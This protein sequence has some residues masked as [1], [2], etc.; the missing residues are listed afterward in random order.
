M[1]LHLKAIPNK[2]EDA[3]AA[4]GLS[5]LALARKADVQDQTLANAESGRPIRPSTAKTI[6]DALGFEVFDLFE[7]ITEEEGK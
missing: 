3:R 1:P 2:L 5:R 4:K 7:R 6:A